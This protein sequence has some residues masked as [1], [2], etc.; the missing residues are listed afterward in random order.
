MGFYVIDGMLVID[1]DTFI[2]ITIRNPAGKEITYEPDMWTSRSLF[3]TPDI[4][5]A[6]VLVNEETS[7]FK[8]S[9]YDMRTQSIDRQLL[10]RLEE[11]KARREAAKASEEET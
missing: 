6:R 10:A 11:E 2:S 5:F 4:F 3:D 1:F 8:T 9:T 7:I